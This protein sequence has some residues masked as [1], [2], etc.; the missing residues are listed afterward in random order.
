MAGY[1][2]RIKENLERMETP[3]TE[4][5]AVPIEGEAK[6]EVD[7]KTKLM[8]VFSF[9]KNYS[10]APTLYPNSVA[11]GIM[12]C[13]LCGKQPIKTAFW[14]QND[15]RKWTLLVGSECVTHFE[16]GK[17]GQ[18]NQRE[19]RVKQAELLAKDAAS[20]VRFVRETFSI[21]QTRRN[22]YG[23]EEKVRVWQIHHVNPQNRYYAMT[24]KLVNLY[25]AG[26]L[27]ILTAIGRD[28]DTI[29][30]YKIYDKLPY[31]KDRYEEGEKD[32]REKA[33]L[34]WYKRNAEEAQKFIRVIKLYAEAINVSQKPEFNLGG[35]LPSGNGYEIGGL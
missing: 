18:E 17:S 30:W 35:N 8:P 14:L 9:P 20:A 22:Y 6:A 25:N 1:Q 24:E 5:S 11:G 4:W 23:G 27:Q 16:Q 28:K 33:I 13:E 31:F 34:S 12:N 32:K 10:N 3:A 19:F 21:L 15:T 7:G 2:E 26:E 29:V